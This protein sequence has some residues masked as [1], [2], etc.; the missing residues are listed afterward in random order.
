MSR[1]LAAPQEAVRGIAIETQTLVDEMVTVQR[2]AQE[3]LRRMGQLRGDQVD[4]LVRD[5]S[6]EGGRDLLALPA[7]PRDV[8]TRVQAEHPRHGR[9]VHPQDRPPVALDDATH[10]VR[11]QR[12]P[13]RLGVQE[14]HGDPAGCQRTGGPLLPHHVHAGRPQDRSHFPAHAGVGERCRRGRIEPD[15]SQMGSRSRERDRRVLGRP[16][17]GGKEEAQHDQDRQ[18]RLH[19]ITPNWRRI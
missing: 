4:D 17:R 14:D 6:P 11:A 12:H 8:R 13:G 16:R 19:R 10:D 15:E 1:S 7:R 2:G 3:S 18:V 5:H 9:E